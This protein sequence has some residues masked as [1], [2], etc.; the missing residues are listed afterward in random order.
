MRMFQPLK[1]GEP[2]DKR[3]DVFIKLIGDF[4]TACKYPT[5]DL[6]KNHKFW[7]R[8]VR[9]WGA[10]YNL[11][12]HINGKKTLAK[13][14]YNLKKDEEYTFTISGR[15]QG[16]SID[17]IVFYEENSLDV[18]VVKNTDLATILPVSHR[19]NAQSN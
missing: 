12:A 11:E 13:V 8:G 15:A 3:N 14:V 7:G 18:E 5:E 1:D 10:A 19:P 4:T 17:Y 6:K 16:C 9:K 2:E